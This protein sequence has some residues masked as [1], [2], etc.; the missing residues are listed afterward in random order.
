MEVTDEDGTE[1]EGENCPVLYAIG[2]SSTGCERR[3][4][5]ESYGNRSGWVDPTDDT[6]WCGQAVA[7]CD[8]V[9]GDPFDP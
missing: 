6:V 2:T 9:W 1:L 8:P 4:A 7:D 3:A 5:K